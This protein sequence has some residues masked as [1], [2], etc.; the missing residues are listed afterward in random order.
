[1]TDS[2]IPQALPPFHQDVRRIW[3]QVNDITL[4]Q[5]LSRFSPNQKIQV[6]IGETQ[7]SAF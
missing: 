1:M 5:I 7:K 4:S 3:H 2:S 6:H